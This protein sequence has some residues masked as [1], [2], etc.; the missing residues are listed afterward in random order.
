M[1]KLLL[2]LIALTFLTVSCSSSKKEAENDADMLPDCDEEEDYDDEDEDDEYELIDEDENYGGNKKGSGWEKEPE[3]DSPCENFANTDGMIRYKEDDGFECGCLEGYFWGHLGCKKITYANICTGQKKCYDWYNYTHKCADAGNLSGQDPYYSG[4]GYCIK[5]N[6]SQKTYY[7]D[8]SIIIDNTL[9]LS[10]TKK[11]SNSA[12][13]WENAGEYCENLKYGGRDDWRLPL[14]EELRSIA[15]E[16]SADRYLWSS[17][18]IEGNDTYAWS[19]NDSQT[20]ELRDKEMTAYVR[21]VRGEPLD[22]DKYDSLSSRFQT[23]EMNGVEIVRDLKSG[24]IWQKNF[25]KNFDWSDSMV[26]CEHSDFAGFSDW[27]LPN[28]QI[29]QICLIW[30]QHITMITVERS[31][32]G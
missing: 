29:T 25:T 17:G 12:F 10:W 23:I 7:G 14:P 19:L 21:C 6:F 9:H 1:K 15:S 20:L 16:L 22:E 13:T 26:Y 28:I 32:S 30:D 8:E 18:T 3:T 24:I 11:V 31:L 27:R 2:L 5:Q 4:E